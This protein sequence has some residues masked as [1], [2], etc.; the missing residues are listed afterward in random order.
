MYIGTVHIESGVTSTELGTAMGATAF[1]PVFGTTEEQG[2]IVESLLA[3]GGF[4]ESPSSALAYAQG[5]HNEAMPPVQEALSGVAASSLAPNPVD[6][7]AIANQ[8]NAYCA[9]HNLTLMDSSPDTGWFVFSATLQDAQ[10]LSL[11]SGIVDVATNS[12]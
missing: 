6:T 9:E 2:Y 8:I 11:E 4:D 5:L 3:A 7:A 12:Y 10:N 1:L